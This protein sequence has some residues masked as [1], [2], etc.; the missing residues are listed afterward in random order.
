M[1]VNKKKIINF[2]NSNLISKNYNKKK[3]LLI[4]FDEMSGMNSISNKYEN[5]KQF[6]DEVV[7]LS[8]INDF[9]LYSNAFTIADNSGT[10]ISYL[11]NFIEKLDEL[12][13]IE[14]SS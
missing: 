7:N 6:I 8:K 5:G 3:T 4:I 9:N 11:L 10:S 1:A 2:D 13:V 14:F 12:T